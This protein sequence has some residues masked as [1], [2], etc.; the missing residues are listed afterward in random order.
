[1]RFPETFVMPKEARE[2]Q[3]QIEGK[4]T[5]YIQSV[6]YKTRET[7]ASGKGLNK[8]LLAS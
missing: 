7:K 2:L 3:K 4:I 8:R 1:M 6:G 5:A